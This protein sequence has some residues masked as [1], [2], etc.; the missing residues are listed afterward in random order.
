MF[1]FSFSLSFC[2]ILL[3]AIDRNVPSVVSL[4]CFYVEDGSAAADLQLYFVFLC[5]TRAVQLSTGVETGTAF[6]GVKATSRAGA[7]RM[8]CGSLGGH[9]LSVP[10]AQETLKAHSESLGNKESYE[11]PFGDSVTVGA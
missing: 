10:V 6:Y 1:I 8:R 4:L 7:L 11:L 9:I 2:S 5:P 3:T